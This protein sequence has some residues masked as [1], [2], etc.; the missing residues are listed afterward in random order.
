MRRQMASPR[1]VPFPGSL[2]EKKGSKT[3]ARF[4]SDRITSYNVCYTK[5]L[6]HLFTPEKVV[7]IQKNLG[8]DVMMVLDECPPGGS[9]HDYAAKSLGLTTRWARR[10]RE[11]YPAG[12]GDQL[13]FGIVQ[14]GIF[15]DLREESS[16]NFV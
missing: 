2:V 14:G 8:S 16:Y 6:R 15:E 4:S 12:S 10:C 1:P 3:W 13:L 9:D 11:A 5:L 7:S